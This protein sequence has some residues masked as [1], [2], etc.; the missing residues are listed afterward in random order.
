MLNASATFNIGI[1]LSLWPMRLPPSLLSFTDWVFLVIA[2]L[3]GALSRSSEH[4]RRVKH[5]RDESLEANQLVISLRDFTFS[6]GV[7]IWKKSQM[8]RISGALT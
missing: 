3:L 1:V 8:T 5:G 2:P 4:S 6:V 7:P